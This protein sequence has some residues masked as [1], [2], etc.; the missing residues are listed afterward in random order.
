MN[1]SI[2]S[3][4]S[5]AVTF[6]PTQNTIGS[7]SRP[8]GLYGERTVIAVALPSTLAI[9]PTLSRCPTFVQVPCPALY[10]SYV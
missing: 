3:F 10:F 2:C 7:S 5:V 9:E 4:L 6:R 8:A 1:E